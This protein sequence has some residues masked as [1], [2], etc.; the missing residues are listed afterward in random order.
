[1]SKPKMLKV[2]NG[3]D[4]CCRNHRDPRYKHTQPYQTRAAAV[5]AHSR[6]DALRVIEEYTGR[7]PSVS[8][9]R[10]FWSPCWGNKMDGITPERGLW[11]EFEKGTMTRVV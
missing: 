4:L 5:A 7:K 1:M 8:Y 11:I 2:W 10:D 9:F 6:A 3:Y